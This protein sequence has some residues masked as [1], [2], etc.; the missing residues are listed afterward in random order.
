M[1]SIIQKDESMCYLCAVLEDDYSSKQTEKH[2]IFG[3]P[4]RRMSEKYGLTVRLCP[5]HHRSGPKAVHRNQET[6]Q[7]LHETGE[8]AYIRACTRKGMNRQQA[9]EDFRR[10]FRKNY[11]NEEDLPT[12]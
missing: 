6:M 9:I 12:P 2:H 4:D 7:F 10:H 11:V 1:K 5:E 3:G 8:E